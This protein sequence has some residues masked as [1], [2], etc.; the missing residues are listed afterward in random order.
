MFS[1][2]IIQVQQIAFAV[3]VTCCG[4][5]CHRR[6][7]PFT[8]RTQYKRKDVQN[9]CCGHQQKVKL[10]H[11]AA[12]AADD[13][14]DAM[15]LQPTLIELQPLQCVASRILSFWLHFSNPCGK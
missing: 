9:T 13:D 8:G 15:A 7:R 11:A 2:L 3:F 5:C 1:A 14:D 6:R 10:A 4:C 12:A